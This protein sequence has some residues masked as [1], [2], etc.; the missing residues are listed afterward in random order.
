MLPSDFDDEGLIDKGS[1]CGVRLATDKRKETHVRVAV[2]MVPLANASRDPEFRRYLKR[3]VLDLR[4][5]VGHRHIVAF[6]ELLL[7]DDSLCIVL[8]WMPGGSLYNYVKKATCLKEELARWFSQQLVA[9]LDYSHKKGVCNRDLKLE[10]LLMERTA[11][12]DP[13]PIVKLIDFGVC[14]NASESTPH[15]CVGTFDYMPPEVLFTSFGGPSYDGEKADVW[16][17][18]NCLYRMLFGVDAKVPLDPEWKGAEDPRQSPQTV[19]DN[20]RTPSSRVSNGELLPAVSTE[21]MDFLNRTLQACP[22]RRISLD[23]I[24]E[25]PWFQTGLPDD[26]KKYNDALIAQGSQNLPVVADIQTDGQL[27][28]I[29]EQTFRRMAS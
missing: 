21:C 19:V 28:H 23:K 5:L 10:H 13:H 12:T 18:G 25:H 17:V 1:T 22:D 16:L 15:S 27:R 11:E 24:W 29:L 8:E 20:D 2:K 4:R 6:R 3:E 14:K 9:A 26:I 7:S